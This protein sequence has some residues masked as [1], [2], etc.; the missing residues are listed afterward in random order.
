MSQ[1][2]LL[3][4]FSEQREKNDKWWTPTQVSKRLDI[5]ISTAG[6][7]FRK[8]RRNYSKLVEWESVPLHLTRF[9]MRGKKR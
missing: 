9:Q 2:T 1:A 3:E 5:N 4:F 7:N 6:A 8:V